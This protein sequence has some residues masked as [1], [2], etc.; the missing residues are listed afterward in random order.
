MK[1]KTRIIRL[2][3]E[4]GVFLVAVLA[5]IIINKGINRNRR[6]S[7]ILLEDSNA[8]AFQVDSAELESDDIVI[9]GW[10]FEVESIRNVKQKV[11]KSNELGVLIYDIN[12]D[13][14]VKIDGSLK[15]RQ[16]IE[17]SVERYTRE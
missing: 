4:A 7:F 2:S 13:Q 8:Y 1:K 5:L 17:C 14:E 12:S 16:G 11:N 9:K 6:C 10:F 3:I 15:P